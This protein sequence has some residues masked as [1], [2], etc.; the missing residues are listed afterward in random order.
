MSAPDSPARHYSG[1][2]LALF[3]FA[4][5]WK[6]YWTRRIRRHIRG[7]VIEVGAGL[8]AN[9]PW[10]CDASAP[11]WCMEPDPDLRAVLEER[12]QRGDLP[13]QCR[14][15]GGTLADH[16]L[17]ARTILY[18]DVLEHIADDAAE[19]ALAASRLQPGGRLIVLAP[20]HQWL[21]S[22][23][24]AAIGHHRRYT[25][26]TLAR[27]APATLRLIASGYLDSAGLLAS[28]GNRWLLR[29][30]QPT[31]GQIRFW[32]RA[33]I[34]VSRLLDPLLGHRLGKSLYMVWERP[35]D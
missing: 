10:L 17:T 2:E 24:D 35:V 3:E 14:V 11:W 18:L 13:P 34:P 9:T 23:F 16:A 33:L 8:G 1:N 29:S 19:L 5:T 27:L 12:L 28:L 21:F 20:A 26:A 7:T 31:S 15:L 6:A 32:D 25:R 22:P 30:G 4:A